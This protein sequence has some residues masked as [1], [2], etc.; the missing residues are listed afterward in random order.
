MT[1]KDLLNYTILTEKQLSYPPYLDIQFIN[2][3]FKDYT[4]SYHLR[5]NLDPNGVRVFGEYYKY[6][7]VLGTVYSKRM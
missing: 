6:Y 7:C 2:D 1:V 3:E 4:T 5:K